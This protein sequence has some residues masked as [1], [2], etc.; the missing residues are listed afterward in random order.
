MRYLLILL[1]VGCTQAP[2]EGQVIVVKWAKDA[3]EVRQMCGQTS[4]LEPL[5]CARQNKSEIN[6]GGACEIVAIEPR[7]FDDKEAVNTL[8]HEL[9]HCLK[10]PAH[11]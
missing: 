1:L 10:G 11:T 9:L 5:G 6:P 8:G 4:F 7:G 2:Q 3:K